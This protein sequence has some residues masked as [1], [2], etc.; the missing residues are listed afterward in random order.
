MLTGHHDHPCS[1]VVTIFMPIAGDYLDDDDDVLLL[2]YRDRRLAFQE[3][4]D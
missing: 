4:E 1:V 3:Q 2:P